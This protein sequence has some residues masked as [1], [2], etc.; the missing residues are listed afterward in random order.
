[1]T[2]TAIEPVASSAGALSGARVNAVFVTILL[3][4]LLAALDQTI[5]ST[6]LPTITADLGGAAHLSWVVTSYLLAQTVSVA[7]AGK[8]GD[9]FGRKRIF[10]L[11]AGIFVIGSMLCG[12]ATNMTGLIVFRAVQGVGGVHGRQR[13]AQ[14]GVADA[15]G[16]D[17]GHVLQVLVGR[18]VVLVEHRDL[19]GDLLVG[20]VVGLGAVQDVHHHRDLRG[21][22]SPHRAALPRRRERHALQHGLVAPQVRVEVDLPEVVLHGSTAARHARLPSSSPLRGAEPTYIEQECRTRLQIPPPRP[23]AL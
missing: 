8:F 16:E 17:R 6:A 13:E 22:L 1:M 23:G 21:Q 12:L 9:L 11:S 10:Q 3:G 2:Q 18:R 5:V 7:L 4:I 20:E 15:V 14:T 19:G